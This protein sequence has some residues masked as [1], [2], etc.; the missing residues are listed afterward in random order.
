VTE[1]SWSTACPNW[2]QLIVDKK[3]LVPC[4]PLF[5]DEAEAA[6]RIFRELRLVDVA[7]SPT[8]GEA[9]R[10]F[11]LDFAE[12]VFGA[13]D[14]KT[15]RRLIRY[16]FLL[17]S[18]KNAKS[19]LAAAI[20]L[21]AL[22]RN[23]RLSGEYYILAPTKEVADNSYAP[24]RDMVR[25]DEELSTLLHCQDNFRTITHRNTGAF[26]R[27]VAADNEVVAGKKTIGLFIDE[28]WLFGK[29][30]AAHNI[31]SEAMGGLAS[32]PEGFVIYASTQSDAQ[33]A[34][35]FE[36][37]L[38][39]FRGIRDGTIV[40][41]R[42]LGVLYEFPKRF[43]E[44]GEFKNRE[45]WYI[46]NPNMHASVDEEF[47]AD[48]MG[49]AEIAGPS[50]LVSFY[51]K[52]LNVEITQGL[53]PDGWSGAKYWPDAADDDL[54]SL[55]RLLERSEVVTI[56]ID[57]G[58]LDDLLGISVI[59]R[60]KGTKNWLCWSH[61]FISPVGWERRKANQTA[62]ETFIEDEDLTKVERLPDD[63]SAVVD[64]VRRCR[65]SRKL[66]KVGCDPAGLGAI[67]D[68]LADIKITVDNET[69]GGV[70][71]GVGLMGA[72][73][74]VERKLLDGSFKH[75]GGRMMSWC[76]GNAI[77]QQTGTG[78]RVARDASGY[79]KIDPL[80][81]M[82]DAAELMATNP[83]P[84]RTATFDMMFA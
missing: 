22:L 54:K 80:V 71:Q 50:E 29:R 62:Y 64:I 20:M 67:V 79:G 30:A 55:S 61:A 63:V 57:G 33:P 35:V 70:R 25:A 38:K 21:T 18:K 37:E 51:S 10:P 23:W 74:T 8:I 44:S 65:D 19:T 27:V 41:P 81:A 56:G 13:Y 42:S 77:I 5:K 36:K 3:S 31:I 14:A 76:A 49:Q 15:G 43:L 11:F 60:E 68:A 24:A 53:R 72:I 84:V 73:K 17:I 45:N 4:A 58:G 1:P 6:M 7:N 48:K 75:S 39:R 32:R 34:G 82:F 28:L 69:L 12:S 66:A 47:I 78:I 52:H 40:D 26:L 83:E 59:G 46:T 16:F 2:E 9:A